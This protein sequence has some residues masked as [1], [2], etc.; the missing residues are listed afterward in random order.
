MIGDLKKAVEADPS[1]PQILFFYQGDVESG[2]AF[3]RRLWP[4]ARAV[5]DMSKKFYKAFGLK[6]GSF[7]EVLGGQVMACGVRA[8]AKGHTLGAPKGD[9]MMMPGLFLVENNQQLWAHDF[10]HVGDHPDWEK[11][12][13]F[14][15]A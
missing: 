14:A 9:V 11:V 6:R 3:F 12:P 5:S 13:Q 1:Y 8:S 4:E 7:S 15:P 10:A 2:E